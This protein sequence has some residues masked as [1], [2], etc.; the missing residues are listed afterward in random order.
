VTGCLEDGLE[1]QF[2]GEAER[3]EFDDNSRRLAAACDFPRDLFHGYG[4]WKAGHDDRGVAGE[5]DDVVCNHDADACEL[6]IFRRIDIET[7]H[8]PS[9]FDIR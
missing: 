9:A 4:R 1:A 7:D 2:V 8:T 5:L 6:G 3:T